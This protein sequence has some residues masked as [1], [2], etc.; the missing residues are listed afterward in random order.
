MGNL[1][2]KGI[3]VPGLCALHTVS[4]IKGKCS[5]ITYGLQASMPQ[6]PCFTRSILA[7]FYSASYALLYSAE[8]E[9]I[10]TG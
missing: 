5:V 4:C 1:D 8:E 10:A 3:L 7:L 2:G 6:N 9:S